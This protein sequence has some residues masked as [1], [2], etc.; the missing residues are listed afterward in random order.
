[1]HH[2]SYSIKMIENSESFLHTA[3]I[4]PFTAVATLLIVLLFYMCNSYSHLSHMKE[5][6]LKSK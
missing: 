5:A 6:I 2:N 1:M 4:S 3:S